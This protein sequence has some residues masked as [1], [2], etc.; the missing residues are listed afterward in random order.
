[1]SKKK[2]TIKKGTNRNDILN[3]NNGNGR[4]F[5]FGGNDLLNA[6]GGNDFLFGGA[7]DDTLNGGKDKDFLFGGAGDDTLNGDEGND[8]LFGG[9]GSDSL[10][11][12]LGNDRLD[13]GSGDDALEGGKGNDTMLGG[14]GNDILKWDDGD[15]S[16]LMSGGTGF[17]TIE[18]N[19]SVALGDS[20]TLAQQGTKAI[21]DRINLVPFK[22]TV[23]TAE[24]FEVSG[25]GGDDLFKVGNL[26]ATGVLSVT[27]NG[28]DGNDSLDGSGTS[29]PLIANGGAG[30][31]TL[32][33]GSGDDTLT[34]GVLGDNDVDVL[35]GGAG[36]DRFLFAG[37]PFTG[38]PVTA[39]N[40]IQVFGKA[41]SLQ[42]YQIGTDKFV[43]DS[44][45]LNINQ[46]NFQRGT[47]GQ[48]S[49]DKNVIVLTDTFSA[50]A[51]AA[52]AIA[53][54]PNVTAKAGVFVYF[55][56]TLQKE[57]LVYSENLGAGG[58]IS[59]LGNLDNQL[60]ATGIANLATFTA[61][62]FSLVP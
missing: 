57:R 39:A 18:V 7:G 23:D 40:G 55:N 53:D 46:I 21:F 15:G 6:L 62:D 52:K 14:S 34:G 22:L 43:L 54:N 10:D 2:T 49:G 12:G 26:S 27:F 51:V 3:G 31:D 50:A 8:R 17:D 59:V 13:G 37:Q 45:D 29:T 48:I 9:A 19:G 16:D 25:E 61:N 58:K 1:M 11:G 35:T 4:L 42:D 33:G 30:V 47:A 32:I 41:D 56:T 24:A 60:G 38:S 5:G 44:S 20:F 36:A 28:N